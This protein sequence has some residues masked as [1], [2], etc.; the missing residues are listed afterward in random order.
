MFRKAGERKESCD[1]P[2]LTAEKDNRRKFGRDELGFSNALGRSMAHNAK[3][4]RFG[5][6]A[7]SF[8]T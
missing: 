2:P 6:R 1:V 5:Q 8:S 3:D 4:V 7:I